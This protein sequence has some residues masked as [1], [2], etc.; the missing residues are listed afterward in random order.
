MAPRMPILG[1]EHEAKPGDQL[2]YDRDHGVGMGYAQRPA[3]AEVGLNID[4]HEGGVHCGAAER[5]TW[6]G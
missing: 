4:D 2:V 1:E 6:R 5:L 3:R